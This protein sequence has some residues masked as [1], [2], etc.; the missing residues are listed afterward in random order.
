MKMSW[1]HGKSGSSGFKQHPGNG[2]GKFLLHFYSGKGKMDAGS[3]ITTHA[4]IGTFSYGFFMV[5]G[6]QLALFGKLWK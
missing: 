3:L 4:V 5:L 6:S 1:A 2:A